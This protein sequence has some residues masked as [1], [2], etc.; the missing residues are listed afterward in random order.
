[1]GGKKL[2]ISQN[3]ILCASNEA[4]SKNVANQQSQGTPKTSEFFGKEPQ[5]GYNET[6][7]NGGERGRR[8]VECDKHEYTSRERTKSLIESMLLI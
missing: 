7:R 1:M 3:S 8:W 4:Y 6:R 5:T 2:P